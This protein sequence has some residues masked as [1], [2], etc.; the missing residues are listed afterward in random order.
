MNAV[1]AFSSVS[2]QWRFS[3]MGG[4]SGLDY[5]A[6]FATVDR[7][8]RD[9]TVDDRDQVFADIQIM[10]RAALDEMNKK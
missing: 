1:Q 6:V 10:E 3:G 4:P 9:L 8:L 7:M 5:P 2:T